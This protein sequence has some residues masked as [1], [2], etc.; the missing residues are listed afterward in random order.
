MSVTML[1]SISVTMST[2]AARYVPRQ[3]FMLAAVASVA[4]I[5]M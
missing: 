5:K 4:T 1:V 2:V 3:R